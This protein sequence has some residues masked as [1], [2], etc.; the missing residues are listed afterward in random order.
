MDS[1]LRSFR[2]QKQLNPE[3]WENAETNDFD[4]IKLKTEIRTNLLKIAQEFI[5]SLKVENIDVEDVLFVGSLANYNWSTYSD[6]DLHIVIDKSKLG[7]NKDVIDEFLTAKKDLFLLKH[8]I[9]IKGFDVE[10][11]AQDVDEELES[12]GQ[13]SILYNKWEDTPT[14]EGF[15]LDKKDVIKKIKDFVKALSAIESMEDSDEKVAKL[16]ALKEKISNYR[17]AGLKKGGELSNEN[18]VFKYL[19][20]CGYM[21]KLLN[22]KLKTQDTLLTVEHPE[23]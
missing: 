8:K 22:L 16:A 6:V 2:L 4:Q 11:Y 20:R 19:R 12:I 10:L 23:L 13:Y 1:I 14:R 21:E 18:L 9:T 17:K 7:D 3:V 15:N 5:D